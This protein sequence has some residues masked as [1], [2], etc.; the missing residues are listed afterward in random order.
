ML[1]PQRPGRG[2]AERTGEH[3]SQARREPR[4]PLWEN[5][6]RVS[7]TCVLA[8]HFITPLR[9][10]NP[11]THWLHNATWRPGV[12]AFALMSGR[13]GTGVP[14]PCATVSPAT[15]A[16]L[17]CSTAPGTPSARNRCRP[18]G[19]RSRCFSRRLA[20]PCAVTLRHPLLLSVP[21]ALAVGL[22]EARLLLRPLHHVVL[23]GS[24]WFSPGIPTAR[25][26]PRLVPGGDHHG[27]GTGFPPGTNDRKTRCATPRRLALSRPEQYRPRTAEEPEQLF[28]ARADRAPVPA[29]PP[30]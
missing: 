16:Q 2:P 8:G 21:A 18:C 9:D 17:G 7:A 15:S 4:D 6:R 13:Y 1:S 11:V 12:P 5:V 28:P 24:L 3:V 25:Q 26:R 14:L 10:H 19:F 27:R 29:P 30:H 20:L 23:C 22:A